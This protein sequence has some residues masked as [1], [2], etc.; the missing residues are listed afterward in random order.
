MTE[1]Q[2]LRKEFQAARF[3]RQLP[4]KCGT[5]CANCGDPENIE[6]HHVVPLEVGGTNAFTNIVPLCRTCHMKIHME[7]FARARKNAK[8]K[9]VAGRKRMCK[10]GYEEVLDLYFRCKIAKSECKKRLGVN[11]NFVDT[12]WFNE[13]KRKAGILKYRNNIDIINCKTNNGVRDGKKLGYIL[14]DDGTKVQFV[15]SGETVEE[16][17]L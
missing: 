3:H 14:Y 5:E 1:H 11:G 9:I 10:D 4:E 17:I 15:Q 13:Y 12:V 8:L 16:I 2:R 6:Y 7:H